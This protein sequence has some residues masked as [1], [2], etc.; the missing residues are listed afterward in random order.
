VALKRLS[1]DPAPPTE[2][3]PVPPGLSAI[4]MRALERDPAGRYPDAGA[5]AEA[6]RVWQ[7][8]PDAS[9][10]VAAAAVLP[11]T[12]AAGEPTVY[13]PPRVTLPSDRAAISGM[14][15]DGVAGSRGAPPGRPIQRYPEPRDEGQPWWIWLLA[16]LAVILLGTIGF[17]GAQVFGGF[18]PGGS[19]TPTPTGLTVPNWVGDPI[20]GVRLEADRLGIVL[21]VLD[22]EPSDTVPVDRVIRTNPEADTPIREGDTVQVVVSSGEEQVAVPIL[23]GQTRTEAAATLD[24]AGLVLGRV[25]NAPS[26]QP[27]GDVIS[28][29]PSSGVPVGVGSQ[30]DIVLSLGPTP[31]PSPSPTPV[32]TPS[33]TPEPTLPPSSPPSS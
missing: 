13:V 22:P 1:E 33:P 20:A 11:V 6:L 23:I 27:A 7:K 30:V 17:L 24:R 14:P 26:D 8:D 28:T 19:A 32:P 12:P 16:V 5:F 29:N 10:A 18:G 2:H 21:D 4:V 31:S 25:D 9:N 3:G 15:G